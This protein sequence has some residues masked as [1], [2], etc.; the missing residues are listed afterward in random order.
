MSRVIIVYVGVKDLTPKKLEKRV[1]EVKKSF[2]GVSR[3]QD[4]QIVYINV[5]ENMNVEVI[6]LP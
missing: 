3:D 1:N 5:Y 2:E 6:T 4:N